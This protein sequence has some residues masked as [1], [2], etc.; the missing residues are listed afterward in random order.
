MQNKKFV[1]N[2]EEFESTK[3]ILSYI[4]GNEYLFGEKIRRCILDEEVFE[5]EDWPVVN[6]LKTTGFLMYHF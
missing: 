4:I 1:L 5:I 2:E 3:K 6:L